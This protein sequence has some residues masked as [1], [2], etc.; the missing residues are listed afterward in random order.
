MELAAYM[1]GSLALEERPGPQVNKKQRVTY[2]KRS[3]PMQE[4]LL[5]LM[6]VILCV[7]AAGAIIWRFSQIYEM[8]NRIA[9]IE[10]EIKVLQVENNK[11]KLE[12]G[13][14]GSPERLQ[15]AAHSL[16][17]VPNDKSVNQIVQTNT[18]GKRE[19]AAAIRP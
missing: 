2:R 18:A 19:T 4:K 3:M 7:V 5:Y 17:L 12:I 16:G 13:K 6:T 14:Q 9:Q 15:E 10:R 1:H 11:L 8:N